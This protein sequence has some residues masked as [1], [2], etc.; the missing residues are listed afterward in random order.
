[1]TGLG[2]PTITFG[3]GTN[4]GDYVAQIYPAGANDWH[5]P[6]TQTD[7]WHS[8]A[9]DG[10]C[11]DEHEEQSFTDW[12]GYVFGFVDT[13]GGKT[14]TIYFH[15]P[16]GAT[17]VHGDASFPQNGNEPNLQ[18]VYNLTKRCLLGGT[19]CTM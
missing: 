9:Q 5:M 19:N 17:S 2:K 16:A 8:T 11:T 6:G 12:W 14:D 1:M 7:D 15:L 10:S 13:Q 4:P 3:G 18:M